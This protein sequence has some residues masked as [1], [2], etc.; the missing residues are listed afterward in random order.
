MKFLSQSVVIRYCNFGLIM[1]S[2]LGGFFIYVLPSSSDV[3]YFMLSL[4][5]VL[6]VLFLYAILSSISFVSFSE[7]GVSEKRLFK[8]VVFIPWSQCADILIYFFYEA[9]RSI[10]FSEQVLPD[11]EF[12]LPSQISK[13][14]KE[15]RLIPV[16]F[17][18]KVWAELMKYI[19]SE[20]VR[21][22]HLSEKHSYFYYCRYCITSGIKKAKS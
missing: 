12:L 7:D 13:L 10:V 16:N 11:G 2:L 21:N 3:L 5:C 4:V 9:H 17:S 6:D 22:A 8:K 1:V 18:N 15:E 19:P 14:R 20:R